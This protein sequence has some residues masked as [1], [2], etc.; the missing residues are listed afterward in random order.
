MSIRAPDLPGL[1]S[2]NLPQGTGIAQ[3]GIAGLGDARGA[4]AS[5]GTAQFD[6]EAVLAADVWEGGASRSLPQSSPSAYAHG[7]D[8]IANVERDVNYILA[9]LS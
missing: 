6:G 1:T 9:A 2:L 3:G 7:P 5:S 4:G 8:L